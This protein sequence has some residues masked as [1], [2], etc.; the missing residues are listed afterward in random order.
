MSNDVVIL[1]RG[2]ENDEELDAACRYFKVKTSRSNISPNSL[3]IGRYSVLPYYK[4]I[5]DDLEYKN[6]NL[7][8]SLSQHR[9]IADIGNWYRDLKDITPKTWNHL[10]AIPSDGPFILKGE[11]NSKKFQWNTHMFAENKKE[12]VDVFCRLQEDGVIAHQNIYIREFVKLKTFMT[13]FRGLPITN[14]YRIFIAYGKV[15]SMGYYWSSHYDEIVESHNLDINQV[16][17]EF[18]QTI[19][20]KVG[21]NANFYVADV[22]QKEDGS[23]IVIELND[24][25]MSGLSM[26]DPYSLYENLYNCLQN[27]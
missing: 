3:V 26:N 2:D 15:I 4:E 23:W 25:Q 27:K 1:Y 5:C 13:S 11:T 6:C 20:D 17:K 8:N 19:I 7:I 16:P 21:K 9:Y 10:D 22:A 14:E 18:I 12:A 24:G